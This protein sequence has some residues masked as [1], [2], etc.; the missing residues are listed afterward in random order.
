MS[1]SER[2]IRRRSN[3]EQAPQEIEVTLEPFPSAADAEQY[4]SEAEI[5]ACEPISWGSNYTFATALRRGDEQ[6]LAVYKPRRGEVP[7]WDFP[8]GT[9]Y[10]REYAAFVVTSALGWSFI[11]TTV[12]RDGPYGVGTVQ[13]YVDHD[14][15]ANPGTF[16][17]TNEGEL[18]RIALF[19]IFANNADRKSNHTLRDSAGKLWG[20]DHGL[21]F[22]AVT[23]LRTVIWDFVG[24]KIPND[25]M[26]DLSGLV[27]DATRHAAL[28]AQLGELLDR[29]EIATFYARV[30]RLLRTGRFP[31]LDPSKN[32]P[33]GFW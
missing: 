11:P 22:N 7:L 4:L 27:G 13:L 28:N 5:I 12:I 26:Q 18:L 31:N 29:S 10:R 3:D 25:V 32:V 30:E 15:R 23:K 8:E 19:D 2:R 6:R 20:I 24:E 16:R 17:Q 33:R 1:R 14:T 21:T 9:L